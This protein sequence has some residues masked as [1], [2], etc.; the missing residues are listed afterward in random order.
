LRTALLPL[1]T[2]PRDAETNALRAF[3]AARGAASRQ[4]LDL[5]VFPESTLTGYL[6]EAEDLARF[7]EPVPGPAT[8]RF[9]DLARELGA[10]VAFG[11]IEAAP[12]GPAAATVLIDRSGRILLRQRKLS[13]APPYVRG[14]ELTHVDP[15]WGTTVAL[16][17]G[18]LFAEGA[19]GRLPGDLRLVLVP[20]AR[21]F[22]GRS[23]DPER[24]R[25]EERAVYLD[26]VRAVGAPALVVNALEEPEPGGA[27]PSFGGA[28]VVGSGGELLAESPH[29]TDLPLVFELELER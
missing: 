14:R 24:W 23:P 1:F 11:L 26:A 19:L 5:I 17:C 22:D 28:M 4:P 29:G 21:A 3:A 9:A 16:A 8:D 12:A 7:A 20:M 2:R 15:G 27:A 6:Y 25:R 18:D 10:N 13:E